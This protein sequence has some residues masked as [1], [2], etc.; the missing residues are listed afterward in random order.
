[1]NVKNIL[2]EKNGR[3]EMWRILWGNILKET[4]TGD[5]RDV[6]WGERGKHSA[7]KEEKI[8]VKDRKEK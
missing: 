3:P 8:R 6:G 5:A 1:M 2:H 4:I 7:G